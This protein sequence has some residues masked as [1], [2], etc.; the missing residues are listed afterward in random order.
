MLKFSSAIVGA[1][2]VSALVTTASSSP[3]PDWFKP[4]AFFS[5]PRQIALCRAA[6][7]ED[8]PAYNANKCADV[9]GPN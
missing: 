6:Y 5:E 1:L 9:F 3:M 4:E 8:A 7:A 2:L